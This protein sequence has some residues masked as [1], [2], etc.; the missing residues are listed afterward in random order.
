MEIISEKTYPVDGESYANGKQIETTIKVEYDDI[1]DAIYEYI[2]YTENPNIK[3]TLKIENFSYDFDFKLEEWI[4]NS[5][6]KELK[7]DKEQLL[8]DDYGDEQEFDMVEKW[9]DRSL[10]EK[11]S[12]VF[13]ITIQK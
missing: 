6:L 13:E 3:D 5:D 9:I 1:Y 4:S 7:H 10:D 11:A 12:D 8:D 2:I